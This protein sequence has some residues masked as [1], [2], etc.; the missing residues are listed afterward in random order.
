[1]T[2]R[3]R[4]LLPAGI[5]EVLPEKAATLER[6]RRTL[7][8]LFTS[9]GYQQVMPPFIEFLDSL[10]IGD[11]DDLNLQT[12]KLTDQLSGRTMGIRADMTPQ[13]ARIDAHMLKEDAPTRL[14]YCG[15]VLRTRP[16]SAGGSRS[17][18]QIGAELYGHDGLQ[19][20]IEIISLMIATLKASGINDVLLDLGH[21]GI[22]EALIADAEFDLQLKNDLFSMLQR[23]SV[24][25]IEST[26]RSIDCKS[27]LKS[28]IVALVNLHGIDNVLKRAREQLKIGGKKVLNYIDY[29]ET[30]SNKL[31]SQLNSVEIHFDLAELRGYHYQND[32]VFT[33]FDAQSGNELARGGRYNNIGEVFGRARP[34]TGFSADLKQ[35]ISSSR[36][37]STFDRN[38][39]FAPTAN[40][41]ELL[42][43][44]T[45]LRAEG[46]TVIT[47]LT[48]DSNEA[49]SL[50]CSRILQKENNKWE[51]KE[52]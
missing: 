48:N 16:E 7:L 23:K 27:D 8:D 41:K 9:W 49:K 44:I 1:M 22:F 42:S 51:I 3:T 33:A 15:T 11:S 20:D 34:A 28:A 18:L 45:K 40:D 30:L 46:E 47:G 38:L 21:A 6:Y 52:I 29:V 10:L 4:W 17:P 19:S 24:P 5:E 2:S 37:D 26:L 14:C 31:S 25:D 32:I 13:V 12:F 36:I 50:G 39:I 35:L 43:T